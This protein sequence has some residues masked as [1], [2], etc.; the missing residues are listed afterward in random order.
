[1]SPKKHPGFELH[2]SVGSMLTAASG[3]VTTDIITGPTISFKKRAIFISP[4]YDL[5]LRTNYLPGFTVGMPQGSL[6]SPPTHQTW[7]S[8]FG[9]TITFP[10]S[11]ATNSTQSGNT[12]GKS[13]G[14]GGT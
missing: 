12:S 5:G 7:K 8:G 1:L 6:T 13:G 14:S 2:W 9:L 4:M 11:T 3:G 10:F